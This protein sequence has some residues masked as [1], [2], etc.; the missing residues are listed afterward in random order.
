[1][2]PRR[3][4]L[5]L[6]AALVVGCTPAASPSPSV[7]L[8]P[9]TLLLGFRPDVQFA[10]FYLAQQAGYFAEAGLEVTIEFKDPA[11]LMRLVADGQAEFGV[12]R[13]A[14]SLPYTM[15]MIC[16]GVGS[17]IMGRLSDRFG[18]LGPAVGGALG[19]PWVHAPRRK[20]TARI[21]RSVRMPMFDATPV[22]RRVRG[23]ERSQ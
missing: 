10:P 5:L 12:A 18:I 21:Q 20:E 1:M 8:R 9:V 4:I 16:F 17:I 23:V 2:S 19:V 7:S 22:I 15:T 6:I 13:S 14:A 11:D 3:L